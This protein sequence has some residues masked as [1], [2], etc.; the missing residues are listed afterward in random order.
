MHNKKGNEVWRA[1][2]YIAKEKQKH[3]LAK[4]A[5]Q[6]IRSLVRWLHGLRT[7]EQAAVNRIDDR[8]SADLAA[9]EKSAVETFDGVLS[10]LNAVELQVDVALGIW[11]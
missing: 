11:I 5:V 7:R 6:M 8:L 2:F 1:A 4:Q 9:S 10:A 3:L